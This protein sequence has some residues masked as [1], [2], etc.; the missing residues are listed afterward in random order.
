MD[1]IKSSSFKVGVLTLVALVILILTILWVK[2]RAFSSAERIEVHFKDV[3]GMRAG[4]GV[5]MMGLRVGQVEEITPVVNG[6][7]SYVKLKFV[8]TEPN[9]TIPK[10]SMISIQQ[11]GLIGEQ[12]LE[13]T[14]PKTRTL[15]LPVV[16]KNLIFKDDPVEIKLDDKYYDVGYIKDTRVV[17]TKTIPLLMQDKVKTTYAYKID[18]IVN[19]PGLILP[20]FM[21]GEQIK[22][23]GVNKMR[24]SALDNEALPYPQTDS[25]YTVI[26]PMRISDFMDLQYKAA[27]S[28][29]ETN[30][31][32]NDLLSDKVIRDLKQSVV[33][34]NALT[35]QATT[36]MEKAEKLIDSSNE[37]L[38]QMMKM[39]DSF[40]KNFDKLTKLADNIAGDPQFKPTMFEATKAMTNFANNLNKVMD[41][42]DAKQLGADL[43]AIVSNVN[44]ISASVNMMTKDQKLKT[45]VFE[46][47]SNVNKA[48]IDLSKALEVVNSMS[49][50][51]KCQM[52]QTLNDVA[53][54]ASNLRKF[55]DKLNKRFLLFRLMF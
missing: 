25:P 1:K 39:L 44:E 50:N 33:N 23:K 30:Q 42:T 18:Y 28:L 19:L 4:S 11:S 7:K 51:E 13:I 5:Q 3:N 54:T 26:E 12:F 14:P 32:V 48:M 15:Y 17:L 24:I 55:T 8:I 31:K 49:P 6:E 16:G 47:V 10:A 40:T 38:N 20:E 27:A 22:T 29:T 41:N 43:N 2:G 45:Q 53:K 34:I 35:A 46:T 36:T 37:D 52:T 21:K 9:I